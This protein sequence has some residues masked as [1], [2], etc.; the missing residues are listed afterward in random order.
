MYPPWLKP[1][2]MEQ[3]DV[4][5][6]VGG[7]YIYVHNL[8]TTTIQTTVDLWLVYNSSRA[9]A[10]GRYGVSWLGFNSKIVLSLDDLGV[11]PI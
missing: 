11:P 10:Y 2:G 4:Y 6:M 3:P 5:G 9:Y 1:Y 7:M 8:V